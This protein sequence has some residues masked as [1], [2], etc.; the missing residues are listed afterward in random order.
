MRFFNVEM[1][2][3]PKDSVE[4]QEDSNVIKVN[5]GAKKVDKE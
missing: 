1:E 5:F 4:K 3:I 2:T